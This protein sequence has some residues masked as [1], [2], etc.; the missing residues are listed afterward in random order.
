MYELCLH[1]VSNIKIDFHR[2]F[3]SDCNIDIRKVMKIIFYLSRME[4]ITKINEYTGVKARNIS[5]LLDKII[6]KIQ[7][8]QREQP[9]RLGGHGLVVQIDETKLN[10]NVRSHRGRSPSDAI[11]ALTFADCSVTPARGYAEIIES[12]L[13]LLS[14]LLLNVS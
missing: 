8:Y 2:Q 5:K 4:L 6:I 10:F 11:W 7:Q 3:F 9:I 13:L 1:K 14:F 12:R